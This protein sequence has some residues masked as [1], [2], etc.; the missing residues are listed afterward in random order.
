MFPKFVFYTIDLFVRLSLCRTRRQHLPK[1]RTLFFLV[2][3]KKRS[4]L[5]FCVF[6]LVHCECDRPHCE[7]DTESNTDRTRIHTALDSPV[8]THDVFSDSIVENLLLQSDFWVIHR[9]AVPR[10]S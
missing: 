9:F 4:F 10:N 6:R 3:I 2:D 5:T 7:C 1:I 8:S